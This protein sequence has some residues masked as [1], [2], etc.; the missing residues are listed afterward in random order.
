MS[1][2]DWKPVANQGKHDGLW[3][4]V[5]IDLCG[6]S[7]QPCQCCSEAESAVLSNHSAES[8]KQWTDESRVLRGENAKL[9]EL[10]E[11]YD[12]VVS[13]AVRAGNLVPEVRDE[14]REALRAALEGR[15]A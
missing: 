8:F 3:C 4:N 2:W 6:P 10:C 12:K 15:G 14:L 9:K 5:C 13:F 11:R 1:E 7:D